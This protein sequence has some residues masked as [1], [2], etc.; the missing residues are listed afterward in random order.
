MLSNL[1]PI[2]KGELGQAVMLGMNFAVGMAIFSFLGF[3]V[4][5]RRGQ[6][7]ILFSVIGICL[8]L[9][10]GGYEVWKVIRI[11]N[12]QAADACRPRPRE[13]TTESQAPAASDA[14][15]QPPEKEDGP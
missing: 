9:A 15:G 3:Y 5:Q 7:G 6:S 2:P 10:Y 13:K 14:A 4:D 11:L 1:F 12:A 8:G